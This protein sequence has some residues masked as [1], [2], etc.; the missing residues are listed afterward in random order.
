MLLGVIG[1]A[2]FYGD[3]VIT[4]AISVMSAV[5]GLEVVSPGMARWVIPMG[6]VI[7]TALFAVQSRG[8][9]R[10][11]RL[12][13]PIMVGW[14]VTLAPARHPARDRVSPRVVGRSRPTSRSSS[15]SRT[16]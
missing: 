2:L 16:S 13:G 11:G 14:F 5:E 1:A 15:P 4:P 7:I 8:T 9:E 6:I 3:S 10:V 12:F